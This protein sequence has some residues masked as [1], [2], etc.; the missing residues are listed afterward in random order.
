M[1]QRDRSTL[2]EDMD[3]SRVRGK[4]PVAARIAGL[5]VVL[6]LVLALAGGRGVGV[7]AQDATPAGGDSGECVA[8]EGSAPE[9]DAGGE[10]DATPV[11]GGEAE[12][13]PVGTPAEDSLTIDAV[14]AAQNL[15]NCYNDR[16]L[17]AVS[18]L[19]TANLLESKF[20][21]TSA[22]DVVAAF[23]GGFLLAYTVQEIGNAQTYD[24][25]RASVDITYVAGELQYVQA[26]WYMLTDG[27][28][29][30]VDEEVLEDAPFLDVESVATVS[31]TIADDET[32]LAFDQTT[33]NTIQEA[34]NFTVINDGAEDHV[35]VFYRLATDAAAGTPVPGDVAPEDAE[36]VAFVN[37]P[38]G[39]RETVTLVGAPVG[40][41]LVADPNVEGS[42]APFSITE[43]AE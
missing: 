4:T 15:V 17:E 20:G 21:A 11:A 30:F 18:T 33:E 7:A 13:G 22:G 24:D 42:T 16:D 5:A 12:A 23:E 35:V 3:A 10:T 41:Y 25:G 1:V 36:V 6:T 2:N 39:D 31:L 38:A 40:V 14:V 32:P 43:P 9:A 37:V 26:T 28:E 19:V 27:D 34:I 29:F 8:N